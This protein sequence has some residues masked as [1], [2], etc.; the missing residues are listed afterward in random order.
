MDAGL[1]SPS[2]KRLFKLAQ[3]E[4]SLLA[5]DYISTEHLFLAIFSFDSDLSDRLV[6]DL[7]ISE[8]AMRNEI[9]KIIQLGEKPFSR[10]KQFPLTFRAKRVVEL[11]I[12]ESGL[13]AGNI[14]EPEHILIGLV[15]EPD[16]EPTVVTQSLKNCGVDLETLL[17]FT[18][19]Y[20]SNIGVSAD[21]DSAR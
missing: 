17:Q 11:A 21:T 18:R 16:N 2:T 13:D 6:T 12:S 7:K 3:D 20:A 5:H 14:V 1:F 9:A 8:E 19:L 10:P 4:A 15:V